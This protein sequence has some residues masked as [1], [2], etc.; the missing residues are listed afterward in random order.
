[1]YPRTTHIYWYILRP[2]W[3]RN[4]RV[5]RKIFLRFKRLVWMFIRLC[6]LL[7]IKLVLQPMYFST[8]IG[9]AFWLI[10]AGYYCYITFLGNDFA[11]RFF[12]HS[13]FQEIAQIW[14]RFRLFH[15]TKPKEISSLFISIGTLRATFCPSIFIQLELDTIFGHFLSNTLMSHKSWLMVSKWL[16]TDPNGSKPLTRDFCISENSVLSLLEA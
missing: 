11:T 8:L 2:K 6:K 3:I 14:N 1:M 16:K 5:T 10:A 13:R 7:V 15:S 4:C 9:N 12:S